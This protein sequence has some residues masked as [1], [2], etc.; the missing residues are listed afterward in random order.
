MEEIEEDDEDEIEEYS[1]TEVRRDKMDFINKKVQNFDYITENINS[2][3]LRLDRIDHVGIFVNE[4][5][6][7]FYD[8]LLNTRQVSGSE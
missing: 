1:V 2:E 3:R 8:K 4:E 7:K 5:M 6:C